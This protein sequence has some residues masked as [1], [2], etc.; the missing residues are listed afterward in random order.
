MEENKKGTFRI[1]L[2]GLPGVGKR[3]IVNRFKEGYSDF[4]KRV[5]SAANLSNEDELLHNK[6]KGR[7]I[8]LNT[9]DILNDQQ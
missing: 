4:N 5:K 2:V 7:G 8:E 1:L 3:T 6:L 9:L